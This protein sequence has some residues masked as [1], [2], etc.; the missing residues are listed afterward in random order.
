MYLHVPTQ[1]AI[2]VDKE[3]LLPSLPLVATL[4]YSSSLSSN[5]SAFG[6]LTIDAVNK[7]M[8]SHH[9]IY[10]SLL[11]TSLYF[12]SFMALYHGECLGFDIGQSWICALRSSFFWLDFFCRA[13]FFFLIHSFSFSNTVACIKCYIILILIWSALTYICLDHF[14]TSSYSLSAKS[15]LFPFTFKIT[16]IMLLFLPLDQTC[17]IKN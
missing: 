10:T 4:L 5:D 17:Q 8:F 14:F 2:L 13:V 3:Y 11:S 9:Q 15:P 7:S 16:V 1:F 6:S 12:G